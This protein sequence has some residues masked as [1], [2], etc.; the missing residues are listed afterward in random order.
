MDISGFDGYVI[1]RIMVYDER[2][3]H[4]KC[5][6]DLIVGNDEVTK[7]Q[8]SHAVGSENICASV[9]GEIVFFGTIRSVKY[10]STY[11]GTNVHV[12]AF[13]LTDMLDSETHNRVF[14]N[15]DKTYGRINSFFADGKVSVNCTEESLSDEKIPD[16]MIQHNETDYGFLKR[17]YN[18]LG[19]HLY[20]DDKK[21]TV[22]SLEIGVKRRLGMN[23]IDSED[24]KRWERTVYE[25]YEEAEMCTDQIF[26]KQIYHRLTED[27]EP[28]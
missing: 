6:V 28:L 23:S 9:D 5:E 7:F 11:L 24:I 20:V 12:E 18:R 16:F 10:V 21:Q 26:E 27:R 22:C 2:D 8:S 3:H 17:I 15:P 13:S 25:G 19:M 4:S 14:Q 1:E